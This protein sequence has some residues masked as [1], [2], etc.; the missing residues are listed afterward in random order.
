MKLVMCYVKTDGATYSYDVILP[1]EYESFE[2]AYGDFIHLL[3]SGKQTFYFVG[4]EFYLYDFKD[5]S[6][7]IFP[8]DFYTLEHWFETFKLGN[9]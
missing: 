7:E 6:D 3:H 9:K 2:Q 1:F 8:P 4:Y 5:S